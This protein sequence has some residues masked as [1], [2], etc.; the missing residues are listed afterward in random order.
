MPALV[1][2]GPRRRRRGA[3]LHHGAPARRLRVEGR[4]RRGVDRELRGGRHP[5]RPEHPVLGH[6][7]RRR[8]FVRLRPDDARPRHRG[9]AA[10]AGRRRRARPGAGAP[11]VLGRGPV[12]RDPRPLRRRQPLEQLRRLRRPV[13]RR[14]HAG[15]R[16]HPRLPAERQ[17]LLPR[18]RHR[19]APRAT[20]VPGGP[21]RQRDLGR[22]DL[23]EQAG[24]VG[25]HEPLRA[26]VRVPRLLD[27]G[28]PAR[29][30]ASRARTRSSPPSWTTP[31]PA[32]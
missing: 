21:R 32:A 29:R 14:R 24:P 30:S 6:E 1:A 4:D 5:G 7:P 27:P 19:R 10:G 22:P 13:R 12:L 8:R 2:P 17:G 20:A 31:M 25:H 18:R 23:P 28:L 16:A 15:E 9:H 26:L 3:V 11:S